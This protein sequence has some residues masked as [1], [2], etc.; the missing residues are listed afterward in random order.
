MDMELKL[1]KG[2]P[3]FFFQ[4][5]MPCLKTDE[6]PYLEHFSVVY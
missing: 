5:L 1:E 3:L 6:I 4:V 2:G